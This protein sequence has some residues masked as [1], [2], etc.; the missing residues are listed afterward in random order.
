MQSF[1]L[2]REEALTLSTDQIT[3]KRI[4]FEADQK[5]KYEEAIEFVL[6]YSEDIVAAWP[7]LTMRTLGSMTNKINALKEALELVNK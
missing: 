2:T 3:V 4:R 5:K 1:R 7:T 6:S